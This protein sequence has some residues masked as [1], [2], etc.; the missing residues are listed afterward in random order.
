MR[1][2]AGIALALSLTLPSTVAAEATLRTSATLVD[3][4]TGSPS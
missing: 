1:P 3:V 2:F 4:D